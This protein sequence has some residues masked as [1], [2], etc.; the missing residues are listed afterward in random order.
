MPGRLPPLAWLRAFEAAARHLSFTQAAVELR[1][2]QTAVSKQVKLLEQQLGEE[3][4]Q[5]KPRSLVLTK[6]GAAYLPKLRDSFAKLAAATDEVFG[7]RRRHVLTIRAAIGFSVN[8]LA[9]RITGFVDQRP[10]IPIR[11][12]SSVWGE[13]F[14]R[15]RLDLDIQYGNGQWPGYR[16]DRLT[17]DKLFPVCAPGMVAGNPPLFTP[18][19]LAA[20]RLLHVIGYED[21]WANWLRAAGA[22][23]VHPGQGIQFDTSLLAFECAARGGGITLARTSLA[24]EELASGRLIKPFSLEIPTNEGFFLLTPEA[25]PVR[26]QAAVF[27][28]WLVEEAARSFAT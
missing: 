23:N 9:P 1:L 28:S 3:L 15:E 16:V 10:E 11:L 25:G 14:D 24:E 20:H 13:D 6:V 18:Q 7:E 19:D 22:E 27:R 8:W 4:F 2:T 21:G 12:V 17:T 5:R 26:S